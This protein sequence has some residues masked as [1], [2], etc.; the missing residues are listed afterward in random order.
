MKRVSLL[1]LT[2]SFAL[3]ACEDGASN[4]NNDSTDPRLEAFAE[5][6]A[7]WHCNMDQVCCAADQRWAFLATTYED[8]DACFEAEKARL[9]EGLPYDGPATLQL[10]R[11]SDVWAAHQAYY[12]TD[13][14]LPADREAVDA[15]D[16]AMDQLY[17]GQSGEGT[18]CAATIECVA[19]LFCGRDG[20]CIPR[21]G[22]GEPCDMNGCAAGFTCH[23]PTATCEAVLAEG[24]PCNWDLE[25]PCLDEHHTLTCDEETDLCVPQYPVGAPCVSPNNCQTQICG[26][27]GL[28]AAGTGEISVGEQFCQD[29]L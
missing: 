26:E 10:D 8:Y 1:L 4:Q 13:C 22:E 25:V 7:D 11:L 12:G 3:P 20:Q 24:D 2:M 9:I 6:L 28:C 15:L 17:E 14:D 27:D 18:D 16:D 19:G 29:D 23:I 21:P 5:N